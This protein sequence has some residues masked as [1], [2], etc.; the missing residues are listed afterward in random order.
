MIRRPAG[1]ERKRIR[2]L[3]YMK[4][5]GGHRG[6]PD[7]IVD[8]I[9]HR[10]P[11]S[12]GVGPD[13]VV[14]FVKA[15]PWRPS[16]GQPQIIVRCLLRERRRKDHH[17]P[18]TEAVMGLGFRPEPAMVWK[19]HP[20][21]A[22]KG[23]NGWW[24]EAEATDLIKACVV[25]EHHG[26]GNVWKQA[27]CARQ[28]G[29]PVTENPIVASLCVEPGIRD[30]DSKEIAVR[31]DGGLSAAAQRVGAR[32]AQALIARSGALRRL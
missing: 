3:V 28:I 12:G 15:D 18:V 29:G 11:G 10:N 20:A 32:R 1:L 2:P 24:A 7:R 9:D 30:I 31:I 19:I 27:A 22:V 17:L 4:P 21:E 14:A 6:Q 16:G 26:G 5:I 23:D 25:T 13:K 8:W